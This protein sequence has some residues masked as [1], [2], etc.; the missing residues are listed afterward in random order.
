MI[1]KKKKLSLIAGFQESDFN[2]D[3]EKLAKD[4]WIFSI[5]IGVVGI[6]FPFSIQLIGEWVAWVLTIVIFVSSIFNVIKI[7]IGNN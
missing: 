7:N 6:A 4:I 1:W 3:K 5:F 2:G